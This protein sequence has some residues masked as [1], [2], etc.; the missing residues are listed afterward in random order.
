MTDKTYVLCC[1]TPADLT[2]DYYAARNIHYLPYRYNL[3]ENVYTDD[4]V[5]MP[6]EKFFKTMEDGAMTKTT[7][8]NSDEFVE[9]LSPFLEKGLDV[10]HVCLSSGI[11]GVLLSANIAKEILEEKYPDRKIYIIDSLAASRGLG[12]LVDKLADLR[13]E[14]YTAKQL[15]DWAEENKLNLHHWFYTTDLT[16][17]VRGGRVSKASGWFGSILNICPLLHVDS[18]GHLVPMK[19]CRGKNAVMKA[20]LDCMYENAFDGLEYAEKCF[21]S[22]SSREDEAKQIAAEIE[23]HFPNLDG[24]VQIEAIGPIIGAHTGPGTVALF[25]WGKKRID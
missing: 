12:L 14:G 23:A 20:M 2:A 7:Q 8:P 22:H 5:S 16:Y 10:V 17:F 1:D 9:F 24:K 11:T 25:F 4:L 6:P 15:Y 18:T 19:K 21:I 13:D 3:D